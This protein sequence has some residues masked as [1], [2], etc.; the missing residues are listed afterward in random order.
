MHVL[1][2]RVVA[3]LRS[4]PHAEIGADAPPSGI[5]VDKSGIQRRRSVYPPKCG[6]AA[7]HNP[8]I[9]LP[10]PRLAYNATKGSE[11]T[12]VAPGPSL[13]FRRRFSAI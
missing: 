7:L 9:T 10:A 1:P 6:S 2:A 12:L 3:G 13:A 4:S 5:N 11:A 8:E